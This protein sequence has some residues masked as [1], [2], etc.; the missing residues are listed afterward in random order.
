MEF[1]LEYTV[2]RLDSRRLWDLLLICLDLDF[3]HAIAT[4]GV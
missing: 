1:K 3:S 4:A 2:F